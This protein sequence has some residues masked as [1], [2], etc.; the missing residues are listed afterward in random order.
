MAARFIAFLL[1]VPLVAGDL[2]TVQLSLLSSIMTDDFWQ[3]FWIRRDY[4][5]HHLSWPCL[6]TSWRSLSCSPVFSHP[7]VWTVQVNL[8]C[9]LW[10]WNV[11]MKWSFRC[12]QQRVIFHPLATK[13]REP[14]RP[15]NFGPIGWWKKAESC[16]LTEQVSDFGIFLT[17]RSTIRCCVVCRGNTVEGWTQ[18]ITFFKVTTCID[19]K[20]HMPCSMGS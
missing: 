11:Q 14:R 16:C 13:W 12:P 5:L 2:G 3:S 18:I 15:T 8:C 4:F 10:P 7:I 6:K 19:I 17:F 1:Q 20:I 9:S